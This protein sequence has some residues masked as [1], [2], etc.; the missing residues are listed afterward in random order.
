[1]RATAAYAGLFALLVAGAVLARGALVAL[2]L[3]A[4]DRFLGI[5]GSVLILASF[6]YSLRKR[7]ILTRGRP[8]A[9]LRLHEFLAW[10][11][12][13]LVLVHGG[14]RFA[15]A[16]PWL[17]QAAMLVV[18]ASGLTGKYLLQQTRQGLAEERKAL[19]AKGLGPQEIESRV[20]WQ[21]LLV[22]TMTRWRSVH[23]PLTLLF[24]VATLAHAVTA[25]LFWRW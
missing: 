14:A 16:L 21:A 2:G 22:G 4:W 7:K 9:Y 3:G 17:A 25:L 23:I 18:V 12:A 20:L 11:G 5:A 19:A 24:G 13:L 10:S 6:L 8:P 1:V 15:T